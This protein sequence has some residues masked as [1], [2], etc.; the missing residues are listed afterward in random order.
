MS[1]PLESGSAAVYIGGTPPHSA[2][3]PLLLGSAGRALHAVSSCRTRM[4]HRG[5]GPRQQALDGLVDTTGLE[6]CTSQTAILQLALR[7]YHTLRHLSH[8]GLTDM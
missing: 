7:K 4:L 1:W 3:A 5:M 8:Y 6:H 2:P